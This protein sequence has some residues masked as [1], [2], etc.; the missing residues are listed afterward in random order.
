MCGRFAQTT[1]SQALVE[2]FKIVHHL[3]LAPRFNLAPTQDVLVVR[4]HADGRRSH[5]YRWGLVPPWSADLSI[6]SRMINA[7]AETVFEKASFRHPIRHQR[8]IIPASGFY[9]W[10][11]TASGKDPLLF[12]DPD[13]EP[14]PL[15]GLWSTWNGPDHTEVHTTSILTTQANEDLLQIH[16]RMPVFL[17]W[18]A[19]DTWL[20]PTCTERNILAPLLGPAPNKRLQASRLSRYVN[21]VRNEGPECWGSPD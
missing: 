1:P 12:T 10:Q 14:L 20:D 7:R 18:S 16:N 13:R 8:C 5:A 2:L 15:A 17:D 6:G 11:K 4:G 3:D 19:V 9:E 21:S